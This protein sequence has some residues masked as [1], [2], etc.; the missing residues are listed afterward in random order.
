[1][2]RQAMAGAEAVVVDRHGAAAV[3]GGGRSGGGRRH[4]SRAGAA[5]ASAPPEGAGARGAACLQGQRS[6][7]PPP[8]PPL[9]PLQFGAHAGPPARRA[10]GPA[11]Q[12]SSLRSGQRAAAG[13][14]GRC[15]C[16]RLLGS[17]S[18]CKR[19]HQEGCWMR[20]RAARCMPV[21][22]GRPRH[23]SAKPAAR[24]AHRSPCGPCLDCAVVPAG[25][26]PPVDLGPRPGRSDSRECTRS[27]CP[28]AAA[29]ASRMV[30]VL[31]RRLCLRSDQAP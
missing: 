23:G 7:P 25:R 16:R 15:C 2:M 17:R 14:R 19:C 11:V 30:V 6:P 26:Q 13:L 31:P 4:C 21:S 28:G 29:C 12:H 9:H 22:E 3:C 5:R 20:H 27:I 18:L 24:R 8:P 1:M 10:A